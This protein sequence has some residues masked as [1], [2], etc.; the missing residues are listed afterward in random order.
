VGNAQS[1][2]DL[3]LLQRAA[4]DSNVQ[5]TLPSSTEGAGAAHTGKDIELDSR[6]RCKR[7]AELPQKCDR[8]AGPSDR[9]LFRAGGRAEREIPFIVC[10]GY[11]EVS[12][13]CSG[14]IRLLKPI[15]SEEVVDTMAA[16]VAV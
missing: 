16:L 7:R 15:T 12:A 13:P 3:L 8:R 1:F 10:T 14:G 2:L 9:N 4:G 6:T 5:R 11:E